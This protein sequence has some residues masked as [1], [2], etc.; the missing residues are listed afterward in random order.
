MRANDMARR[1]N[2]ISQR[3]ARNVHMSSEGQLVKCQSA[4]G[5]HGPHGTY[6]IKNKRILAR[7]ILETLFAAPCETMAS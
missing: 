6:A 5:L 3:E 7:W 2:T 4:L 1:Q